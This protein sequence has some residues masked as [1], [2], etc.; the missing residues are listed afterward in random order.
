MSDTTLTEDQLQE[1]RGRARREAGPFTDPR[2]I[3]QEVPHSFA[4]ASAVL[5]RPYGGPRSIT[6]PERYLLHIAAETEPTPPLRYPAEPAPSPAR[7]DE[8]SYREQ[9]AAVWKAISDQLPVAAEVRHNYTSVRH[10]EFYR[11]G[12]DHIYLLADLHVGRIYRPANN[13]LC[14][15]PSRARYLREFPPLASGDIRLPDCR[16]CDRILRRIAQLDTAGDERDY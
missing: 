2:I 14:Y 11:Q 5:G 3:N 8:R 16:E 1:L 15:T 13:P 4:W 9:L 6:W 7:V 10:L 12:V